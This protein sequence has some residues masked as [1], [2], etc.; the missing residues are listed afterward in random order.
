MCVGFGSG[1]S[2]VRHVGSVTEKPG[3]LLTGKVVKDLWD[4]DN[5]IKPLEV[6]SN[7]RL[8]G[9]TMKAKAAEMAVAMSLD[10]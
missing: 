8:Q 6:N 9:G 5:P 4:D 10:M 2:E 1:E 3:L 7:S